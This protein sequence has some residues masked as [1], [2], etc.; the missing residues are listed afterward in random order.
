MVHRN[1]VQNTDI[2]K[3]GQKLADRLKQFKAKAEKIDARDISIFLRR[4]VERKSFDLS[5]LETFDE[6]S[7]SLFEL[8]LKNKK[9]MC[10]VKSSES[11]ETAIKNSGKLRSLY[12][13]ANF[14]QD[15]TGQYTLFLGFPFIEGFLHDNATYV[16]APLVLFP[17]TLEFEKTKKPYGWH[18]HQ[19]QERTPTINK[20]L[21]S[22]LKSAGYIIPPEDL[23]DKCT[24]LLDKI[25]EIKSP[26]FQNEFIT[27]LCEIFD[28]FSLR[29]DKNFQE[30]AESFPPI[31][32]EDMVK[33]EQN[34]LH[35]KNGIIL[36]IFQQGNSAISADYDM[37][38]NKAL[39]A[40]GEQGIIDDLLEAPAEDNQWDY[41]SSNEADEVDLD[42]IPDKEINTILPSDSSQDEVLLAS[43][44]QECTV[45]RGPPGTGKSQVIANLIANALSKNQLV[46]VVC[47]K[48]A[49]LDVVAQRLQKEGLG[50]YV[51]L[52]ED[53]NRDKLTLYDRLS[54]F[55]ESKVSR[56]EA[57]QNTIDLDFTSKDIDRLIEK[58]SS[59]VRALSKPYFG[60]MSIHELYVSV[61]T[62]YAPKLNLR[63]IAEKITVN[64]LKQLLAVIPLIQQSSIRFSVANHPWFSRKD[65]S[66]FSPLE[67]QQFSEILGRILSTSEKEMYDIHIQRLTKFH[68]SINILKTKTGFLSSFSKEKKE[69]VQFVDEIL[70]RKLGKNENLDLIAEKIQSEL[71]FRNE[72]EILK[73][74]LKD[75]F[76]NNL[77]SEPL[78]RIKDFLAALK[79]TMNNIVEI[80]SLDNQIRELNDT[81]KAVII[82][83]VADFTTHHLPWEELVR[84]EV[85]SHW[86]DYIQKENPILQ[87]TP[88]ESYIHQKDRLKELLFNKR[89]L[90]KRKLVDELQLKIR[91][92]PKY[93]RNKSQEETNWSKFI[94]DVGK[95][96]KAKSLRRVFEEYREILLS[97]APCWLMTPQSV[98]EVFPL[99]RGLF[100]LIVYDEASQCPVEESIPS[101]YRGKRIVIAGD[102]KQLR[103]FD[104]FKIKDDTD[105]QDEDEPISSESL[106][107]LAKRFYNFRPLNWHYRSKSQDLIDFSN[108]AFYEGRLQVAPDVI[109]NPKSIAIRWI[110]VNGTWQNNT[111]Q[112]EAAR[113]VDEIKTILQQNASRNPPPSVGVITFNEKQQIAIQDEIDARRL[114][115]PE[116]D[117][118]YGLAKNP[119]S[120]KNDDAI[121]I[122]NIENVQG[123]ER[124]I[125]IFSIGYAKDSEGKFRMLFGTL[126][127]EGGENRLN[128]AVTRAREGIV[129]IASI[130]PSEIKPDEKKNSGR[131]RLKEYL[132]Y[133]KAVS[134]SDN[135]K[136]QQILQS[137]NNGTNRISDS[138]KIFDSKFEEMVH[139]ELVY[140]GYTVETQ[141]GFSGYRIDLAV[142]HPK[143]PTR[144]IIG[145]ECDGANFHSAKSTR[146]RDVMRQDFLE[147][148]CWKIERIWSTNWWR[149]PQ[150]EI[151]RIVARI[152]DIQKIGN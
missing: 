50:D 126:N 120:K 99:E 151:N 41:P 55:L 21:F 90:L 86:I 15:E 135:T 87:G 133:A 101:L 117:Q 44:T 62:N 24:V 97:I 115:D 18:I 148:R 71:S 114:Q 129:A 108:H 11:T 78:E 40:N 82:A 29:Y 37:L 76:V 137:L 53:S 61:A 77:K 121:F 16:R 36:G 88:F 59:L 20:A 56:H 60:G 42:K 43:Q 69:A 25:S 38:V 96:R 66:N 4:V 98:S 138:F 132:E 17:A 143:D 39:N 13:T 75:D 128:V 46:L 134:E 142:V 19:D 51:S 84:N 152:E 85:Y 141:V 45:V 124:D 2:N 111:N 58:Q 104:L 68:A 34:G 116:F 80:Q 10:I 113:V 102:E 112:V 3:N 100:D 14:I 118:A 72:L 65:L 1:L 94:S 147:G 48:R 67:Q 63:G 26:D 83:C 106:F 145:I 28:S 123:D 89:R 47:Q 73:S 9:S 30:K 127:Q 119:L 57:I 74:V 27:G 54:E 122:K 12:R 70:K 91:T 32:K 107:I 33:L 95:K 31:K 144:Y 7:E 125:I 150:K 149:D 131:Q 136:K 130:D 23:E 105:E 92:I 139:D 49:A 140:R 109:R 35:V 103:P 81:Q 146:E 93:K 110:N 8:I 64:E 6:L 52:I 5:T 79:N 22:F